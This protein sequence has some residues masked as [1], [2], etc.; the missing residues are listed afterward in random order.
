MK[1]NIFYNCFQIQIVSFIILPFL[2]SLPV[3][4]YL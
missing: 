2:F 3:H 1:Y 4:L